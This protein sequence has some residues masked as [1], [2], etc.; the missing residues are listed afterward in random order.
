MPK[1]SAPGVSPLSLVPLSEVAK[2]LLTAGLRD[3][4][5]AKG[6]SALQ[7]HFY[8]LWHFVAVSHTAWTLQM[9]AD[10][11]S[12]L[13]HVFVWQFVWVAVS[14]AVG[15]LSWLLRWCAASLSKPQNFREHRF[16]WTEVLGLGKKRTTMLRNAWVLAQ[17]SAM[18]FNFLV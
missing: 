4:V 6:S 12:A 10:V 18:H 17:I 3:R 14:L 8:G 16:P 15:L 11:C 1:F 2:L 7:W 9:C 5:R 13:L